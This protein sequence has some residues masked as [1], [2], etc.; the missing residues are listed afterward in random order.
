[1]LLLFFLH[2]YDVGYHFNRII[3]SYTFILHTIVHVIF[4]FKRG[5]KATNVQT[6][7]TTKAYHPHH[8]F[9]FSSEIHHK[10]ACRN[11]VHFLSFYAKSYCW[12]FP[13][14]HLIL[15]WPSLCH[16][17]TH[18][19]LLTPSSSCSSSKSTALRFFHSLQ[20]QFRFFSK[21]FAVLRQHNLRRRRHESSNIRSFLLMCSILMWPQETDCWTISNKHNK[22]LDQAVILQK[23]MTLLMGISFKRSYIWT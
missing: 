19:T 22:R 2:L 7:L 3:Y 15:S 8:H 20:F 4:M 6:K 10:Y 5:K 12:P 13:L 1:M 11:Y 17:D 14:F 21:D 23:R 9:L 18:S 16:M